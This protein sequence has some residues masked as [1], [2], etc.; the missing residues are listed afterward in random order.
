MFPGDAAEQQRFYIS[1]VLKKPQRVPVRY[2]FQRVEQLNSYLSHLPCTYESP[3][4]TA[5]TKPVQSFDEA[6]LANLL[7]RM[8][9]ESWQDQYDLTQDSLPQS[10][11]KLLGVLENVEKVVANSNAK[12]KAAKEK[13]AKEKAAKEEA[14]RVRAQKAAE[15]KAAKERAAKEKAAQ[16]KAEREAAEQALKERFRKEQ[17]ERMTNLA[18]KADDT[19]SAK[20]ASGPSATYA[21][22]V[23]AAVRPNIIF[24]G[25][26]NG[27]PS[28]EVEVTTLPTGEI[29]GRKLVRSSG[30]PDWDAAVLRA[31][32]RTQRLPRDVDGRIP[33][34][35][36][37]A[38][39]PK[40]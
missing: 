20:K 27:N 4:A 40:D 38:F 2:F 31:I 37:I 1:N 15:E 10:V 35:M 3:R 11:R 23:V 26:V 30:D 29:L 39:R 13:A 24:P 32:D 28:A 9:P 25:T 17:I 34:P 6:E 12:E 16:E 5:A 7:L 22:K 19:G 18:G 33:S 36:I 14:E 21:G 8:C